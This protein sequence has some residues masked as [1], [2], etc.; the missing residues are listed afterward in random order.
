MDG[1]GSDESKAEF[2]LETLESKL[3]LF[4]C[5]IE[6]EEE[7]PPKGSASTFR[8]VLVTGVCRCGAVP[9]VH[10]HVAPVVLFPKMGPCCMM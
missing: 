4:A 6:E 5:V 9:S 1:D 10:P 3:V 8:E 7:P 2:H